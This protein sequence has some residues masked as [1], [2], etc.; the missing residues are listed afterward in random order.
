[1]GDRVG[2]QTDLK[3]GI[4][5]FHRLSETAW[6]DVSH[7]GVEGARGLNKSLPPLDDCNRS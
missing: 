7:Y 2:G 1:M 5:G 4:V 6:R 3:G